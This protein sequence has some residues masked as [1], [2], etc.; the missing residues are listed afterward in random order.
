MTGNPKFLNN[1]QTSEGEVTFGDGVKGKIVGIGT[2][3]VVG[4]PKL[5][6]ALLVNGLRANLISISQLYDQN[7]NVQ[8]SRENCCVMDDQKHCVM[9]GKRSSDNF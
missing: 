5:K 4:L 6:R 3:N 8:F 9:E 2:L 1:V 7:W